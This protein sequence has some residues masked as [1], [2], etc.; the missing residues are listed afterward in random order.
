M[1]FERFNHSKILRYFAYFLYLRFLL[2]IIHEKK[3]FAEKKRFTKSFKVTLEIK[4]KCGA[5]PSK[6]FEKFWTILKK[7]FDY[8]PTE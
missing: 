4:F 8:L 1:Q 5:E 7:W 6:Y 3:F 2:Y